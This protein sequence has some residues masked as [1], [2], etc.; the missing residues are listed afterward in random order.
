MAKITITCEKCG[1]KYQVADS[2]SGKRARCKECRA[3]F[4]IS[5]P[6]DA[7]VPAAPAVTSDANA[8]VNP[9]NWKIGNVIL[10][11]YEVLPVTE[12]GIQKTCHESGGMGKVYKVRNRDWDMDMA[13]KVPRAK[14][15][16]NA[17]Q[18]ENFVRECHAWMD[19]GLHPHIVSCGFVRILG[20]IPCVFA[21]YLDG[22]S[23]KHW[24]ESRKL[25]E[26]G[27]EKALGRILDIAIQFARGLDYAHERKMIHQDVKPANLLL[28]QAEGG[29]I[30]AKVA[31]FGL[32]NARAATGESAVGSLQQSILAT[33]GGMTPAYCSPEQANKER[34]TRRTDIWSWALSVLEMF[35]GEVTWMGGQVAAEALEGYLDMGIDDD[36]IPAMPDELAELL[37][38]CFQRDPDDR[39]KTMTE[40]S[41]SFEKVYKTVIGNDY[42]HDAPTAPTE[43]ADVLNNKALSFLELSMTDE[44]AQSWLEALKLEPHHIES[45][46]NLG[47][48]QWRSGIITG[49]KLVQ[50]ME[51]MSASHGAS[52][53]D[54]YLLGLIHIERCDGESAIKALRSVSKADRRREEIRRTL[55]QASRLRTFGP[56][57]Y[58]VKSA[59]LSVDGRYALSGGYDKKLRL[60]Q[61]SSGRCR[62][63]FKGHFSAVNS[64]CLSA[65]GRYAV[66][67][68]A[69]HTLRLWKVSTDRCLRVFG[70][71]TDSVNSV[72][73]SVDGRYALSGSHDR[74]VRLWEVSSG[75]C[76]RTFEGHTSIVLSVCLSVD[77]RYAL[78]GS[79]D[80]TVR[81]WEVSSGRCL[82]TFEGHT[83]HVS[84]VCLSV[85]GRYAL[86]GSS[87]GTLRLWDVSAGGCLRTFDGHEGP[88]T[89]VCLSSDSRYALSG[90]YDKTVRLWDVSAGR[91]LRTFKVHTKWVSCVCLSADG[92][93]VLSGSSDRTL[94]SW[95]VGLNEMPISAGF[96]MCRVHG[97]ERALTDQHAFDRSMEMARTA[98]DQGSILVA[99]QHIREMRSLPGRRRDRLAVQMW[100]DLYCH[101]PRASF[102]GGWQEQVFEG[103]THN[104][105]SVCLSV[106]GRHLLSQ[107]GST[108]SL[109]DVSTGRCLRTFGAHSGDVVSVCLSL[110]GR[111]ALSVGRD[112]PLRFWEVSTGNC[113]RTFEE[114]S[115]NVYSACLSADG[116]YALSGSGDKTVRL[117]NVSTGRCLR[118]LVGHTSIVTSVCLSA[119]GRYA[120]SGSSDK[121]VRLWDVSTGRC[122]RRCEGHSGSVTSIC[123]SLDGR[124]ALSG[125]Y[126]KT[127]RLWEVFSGYCLRRFEGHTGIVTSVCLSAD[128]RYALSGSHDKTVRLWDVSSGSC[129]RIFEGDSILPHSVCLS[130]DGR[131][132]FSNGDKTVRLWVLDWELDDKALTDWSNGARP[133]LES[134]L[135]LHRPYGDDGITH[136]GK[137]EWNDSDFKHL[138]YILG[139]A[140]YGWLRPEGVRKKLEE[141]T[142]KW[143]GPPPL[144]GKRSVL[145]RMFGG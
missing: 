132:A 3:V 91:C 78:S 88:V 121:M 129:L 125:S 74:T 23:L 136:V 131:Y 50:R 105:I 25:Y 2:L 55:E 48:H 22:G 107:D 138:V 71:H 124:Y 10:D 11:T 35:T 56:H 116:R 79:Y 72:C 40:V 51:Q 17:S 139:C 114:H 137:P 123:L 38:H 41:E 19:L 95:P 145:S 94:Q 104:V 57:E 52:W 117:W 115:R 46:Y 26:G 118:T 45:T 43:L 112:K 49:E 36:A 44:A 58:G 80:K 33:Y 64:V 37:K 15:F 102:A 90:S 29:R 106:D 9:D 133:Y 84:S 4:L 76:L 73:L 8:G 59:C 108:L 135:T 28:K 30:M 97:T 31:D 68:S 119:D 14:F 7:V 61:V 113:L 127:V 85:D 81:L 24:I 86:S 62:R 98:C 63:I 5:K 101:L 39:P 77:G 143:K 110:D 93:Y 87:D 6:A 141:M 96:Q 142:A 21:E 83:R 47:L 103:H 60:W 128:G 126:D 69:D 109:W 53:M 120:F 122:L 89:S 54:E 34:L 20:G 13:V 65:D 18:K 16:E 134:F 140:G 130:L 100:A 144:G 70:G 92:R 111:Y 1:S 82:R 99:A 32:A 27:H 42:P 67:G 66:S 75:R 12:D